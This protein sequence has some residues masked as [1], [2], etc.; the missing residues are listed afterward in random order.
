MTEKLK[1]INLQLTTPNEALAL[2]GA[3]DKYLKQ[4]ENQ[5]DV[6]IVTRGELVAVSGD[7]QSIAHVEDILLTLLVIIRKGLSISERDIV[8][9]VELAKEGE[10]DQIERLLEEE[11]MKNAKG[12]SIRIKT[13]GQKTYVNA[14]KENDLVFGIG[15]AGTG[16]TY[17][18]VVM[19][20]NALKKG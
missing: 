16:K 19:A 1:E 8:Y 14:M 4:L 2:F 6:S 11:I 5:L 3:N 13:R 18:A 10:M 17:L 20:I 7:E 15:P 9:A 12:K